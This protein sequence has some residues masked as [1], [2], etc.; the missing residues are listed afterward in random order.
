MHTRRRAVLARVAAVSLV[1]ASL[2]SPA[3][4]A[5]G[6]EPTVWTTPQVVRTP[7]DGRLASWDVA[8]TAAIAVSVN[9][10]GAA[11]I[12]DFFYAIGD[13]N[14]VYGSSISAPNA[15]GLPD[16]ATDGRTWKVVWERRLANGRFE[17]VT[18]GGTIRNDAGADF[19]ISNVPEL[20]LAGNQLS[21]PQPAIDGTPNDQQDQG[22]SYLVT[23]LDDF[24]DAQF[25]SAVMARDYINGSWEPWTA[26]AA[27]D[28]DESRPQRARPVLSQ[29][30]AA[31][32]AFELRA[33]QSGDLTLMTVM[34]A[35][36]IGGQLSNW[37]PRLPVHS[38]AWAQTTGTWDVGMREDAP[39]SASFAWVRDH[40]T[41]RS[42]AYARMA[43]GF[44]TLLG[45]YSTTPVDEQFP[46][47]S[48]AVGK[49]ARDVIG[50]TQQARTSGTT[51]QAY[52]LRSAV[53]S[54]V[55]ADTSIVTLRSGTTLGTPRI[56][57]EVNDSGRV[58]YAYSTTN[59]DRGS[60]I[61]VLSAA[62]G[63][64]SAFWTGATS[65]NVV[66]AAANV[67]I[68]GLGLLVPWASDLY[69]RL[70]WGRV[71]ASNGKDALM[72]SRLQDVADT[73]PGAPRSVTARGG[74]GRATVT[75][76]APAN[77]GGSAITRY[78]VTS[79]PG[80]L[81]CTTNGALT[82]DV[83]GLT[84]GTPYSFTVVATN[85]GGNGPAS[86]ASNTVLPAPAARVPGP[87][88][89]VTARAGNG[90][91]TIE[92]QLPADQGS[93]RITNFTVTSNP[94]NLTCTA[95]GNLT[96]FITGLTNGTEYT[97]TVVATNAAGDG[98]AS[99]P[100]NPVTPQG[101]PRVP[102][103][104]DNVSAV[105]GNARAT[106]TWQAP[107][108]PG[109]SPI[110]GYKAIATPGG[111]SCTTVGALTCEIDGLTNGQPY[112]F[113]V[114]ATNAVGASPASTPSA[115]VTPT[116]VP[117]AGPQPPA[118][119]T[120]KAKPGR[121]VVVKWPASVSAGV[122][123]YVV[124]VQKNAGAWRDRNVGNVLRKVYTVKLNKT[125]C[126]RV[127]AVDGAGA[128]GDWTAQ[129]CVRGRP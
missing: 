106:V 70:L 126:Y 34:R 127:A 82:C 104:P 58:W 65:S 63:T 96:C 35:K 4:A 111:R 102:A 14:W 30:G 74:D 99:L 48:L 85:S 62:Y 29:G 86:P 55:S 120:V 7:L 77:P 54:K 12:F 38:D 112:T 93:S 78:T 129:K 16:I 76:V 36:G 17:A 66:T 46:T 44:A 98:P 6:D 94:G 109:S 90:N 115:A 28:V 15:I 2:T 89:N 5:V 68:A 105:P 116:G 33:P 123:S 71:D 60:G 23:Y 108:D 49:E 51:A 1:A 122:A 45:E 118:T 57:M 20:I 92:W 31:V 114:I 39:T 59:A 103:R 25:G 88:L 24:G 64:P 11:P 81:Q 47:I 97:F 3:L 22:A 61:T 40:G 95:P 117:G 113:S 18:K 10:S 110:T 128:Q 32:V 21:P 9:S 13:A 121:K 26:L 43:L 72:A 41:E 19:A 52:R 69:P 100:S 84:N 73:P 50:W 75:W 79:F 107:A 67:G 125:F 27:Y 53:I 124:G 83:A 91:A 80:G 119:L 87:S 37:L 42:I 8:G 101:L 56:A